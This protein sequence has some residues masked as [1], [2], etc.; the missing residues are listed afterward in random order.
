MRDTQKEIR[1]LSGH[2]QLRS[3]D[4]PESRLIEGYALLFDSESNNLGYFTEV[5]R[6]GA[7]T[8]ETVNKC[9]VVALFDHNTSRGIL[10]RSTNGAG[11]LTLTVDEKGLKYSFEA[12]KTA[13]GD[14]MI[15]LLKRGDLRESS[16]AFTCKSDTWEKVDDDNY[17]RY[18][19]EIDAIYDVSIVINPAYSGTAVK[20]RSFDQLKESETKELRDYY[21]NL[22]KEIR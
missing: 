10:A 17:K 3:D 9:D 7:I 2:I 19:N 8:Q 18:I 14:E 21:E 13:L 4:G 1:S 15:E 5:I 12:P 6:S 11:S 16:F 22:K 20:C